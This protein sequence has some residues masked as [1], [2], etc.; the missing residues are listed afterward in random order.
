MVVWVWWVI[1]GGV[2]WSRIACGWSCAFLGC[3]VWAETESVAF[4]FLKGK[5][6]R[7][8]PGG[9]KASEKGGE[10][11]KTAAIVVVFFCVLLV[12]WWF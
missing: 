1:S 2:F 7:S 5:T 10:T 8:G 12:F 3:F 11:K 9:P 4:P 6:V